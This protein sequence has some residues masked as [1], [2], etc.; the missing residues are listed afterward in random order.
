MIA[1]H[2]PGPWMIKVPGVI[3][4]QGSILIAKTATYIESDAVESDEQQ[5]ANDNL[6]AAAPELLESLKLA[7]KTVDLA[8]FELDKIEA[9]IA[10][11]EG[12][13]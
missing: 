8:D 7:Y 1:Q 6:V 13:S 9:V 3:T 12:R 4:T 10:K 2:S 5:T 11:A